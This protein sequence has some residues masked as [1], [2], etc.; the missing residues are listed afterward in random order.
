MEIESRD[1]VFLKE[2]F[3]GR[4]E[5]NRDLHFYEMEDLKVGE[6]VRMIDSILT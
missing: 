5:I 3:P 1:V 4:G 6:D 2:D